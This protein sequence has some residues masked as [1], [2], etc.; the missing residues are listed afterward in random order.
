MSRN[1]Q[2]AEV[3]GLQ[4]LQAWWLE[5]PLSYRVNALLYLLGGTA[6]LV[7]VT[8]LF[9]GDD[10]PRQISVGAGVVTTAAPARPAPTTVAPPS[11]SPST[12]AV[13]TTTTIAAQVATPAGGGGSSSG[14][15]GGGSS[16][17]GGGS[18][19]GGGGGNADDDD[20]GSSGT[21]TPA[22]TPTTTSPPDPPIVCLN[23]GDERCGAFH[24]DPP[25]VQSAPLLVSVAPGLLN[26]KVGQMAAFV[27][28]A[29][30]PDHVIP[31]GCYRID[32]GD[33]T[34]E[35]GQCPSPPA[36]CPPHYGPWNPPPTQVGTFTRTFA[37]QFVG[38]GTY[39]VTVTVR[40]VTGDTCLDL[41]P[42]AN[43]GSGLA[44]VNVSS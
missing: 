39:K 35:Q 31:A 21:P 10:E 7:L 17:G 2:D 1:P 18:T 33:G 36:E 43:E 23:S 38:P 15:G 19:G 5:L 12:S 11:T 8:T 37:H 32:W 30:D 27:V 28:A 13:P 41:D 16:G 26:A 25:I 3:S 44:T 34:G 14:G 40:S 6:L 4:R 42:W 9:S 24:W 29:S 20:D 22:S